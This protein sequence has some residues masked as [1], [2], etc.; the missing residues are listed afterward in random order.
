MISI[1]YA[2][3]YDKSFNHAVLD[4]VKNS[5]DQ[6]GK[7]YCVFDLYAD[8]FNP[9]LE[10]ASLRLYSR[11]E[12]AD[13]LAAKYLD[14]LLKS[15]EFIMIFPIWWAT[16]PAI[17]K[18]F[19]DKVMLSGQAYQYSESGELIP[20]KI[21][22]SRTI[23]FT[24]SQSATERFEPF[25]KEYFNKFVLETVGMKNLEW[26]NCPQTA[27]GPA[28]NRESFLALVKQKI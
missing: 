23:M 8:G 24:T 6:Q 22:I 16:I 3:P 10:A 5:L 25:F 17:V 27:H 4:T 28:E 11:G 18:G 1:L 14:V 20:N 26:Y 19:F 21:D 15:D 12:T 9:A 7:E 2:H 13:P